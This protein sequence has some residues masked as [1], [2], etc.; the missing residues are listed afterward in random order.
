MK[1][2]HFPFKIWKKKKKVR[3]PLLESA[4]ILHDQ[5]DLEILC[6]ELPRVSNCFIHY[7]FVSF[8]NGCL[9]ELLDDFAS[10]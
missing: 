9:L 8:P 10:S 6:V 4:V 3:N 2:S 7:R 5:A 1:D